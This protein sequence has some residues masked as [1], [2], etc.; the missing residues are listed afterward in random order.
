MST[1]ASV[2]SVEAL[3]ELRAALA[4]FA[5]DS[6]AA[7]GGVDME[8]RRTIQW[9]QHDRTS[10]W[11]QQIKRRR[12]AVAAA[13]AEVFRRKLA[14]SRD[15]TPAYSEQKEILR[16]AEAN[17]RDAEMRAALVKKWQ[18]ALQQ[19]VLEYR[20][21]T[22]RMADISR[23]DVPRAMAV[24]VKMIDALEA[25]LRVAPP[26]GVSAPSRLS[27]IAD[28]VLDQDASEPPTPSTLEA[29]LETLDRG[30]TEP[31]VEG[32]EAAPDSTE[33]PA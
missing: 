20:A 2:H 33:P 15:H 19:A 6:L 9:L 28:T 17:L 7:L 32:S 26:S 8:I 21:S 31:L 23:G 4:L 18:P 13:Q 10:Y 27:S 14:Q 25:Y 22:R 12:E 3:K 1:Q 16:K 5:E 29:H 11:Q 30:S 24:L